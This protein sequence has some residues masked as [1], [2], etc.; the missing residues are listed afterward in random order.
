MKR[1]LA[2]LILLLL[3]LLA[4]GCVSGMQG[5]PYANATPGKKLY[6]LGNASQW[7]YAVNMSAN[8]TSSEWNMTVHNYAG[9]PRHMVIHTSGNGMDIIYDVWWNQTTYRVERMHAN[10]SIG[11]YYQDHDVSPLQIQTLP[12][13]G[14]NYYFVP[15]QPIR[16]VTARGPD[17]SMANLTV[18]AATDNQGFTVAYWIHPAV[19]V[20]AKI[21]MST[22]DFNITMMLTDYKQGPPLPPI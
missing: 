22:R 14:L 20:P 2:I 18:Y 12:D 8:E 16:T 4:S 13:T 3:A 15:F 19:P 17:G 11:D 9:S 6:D 1:E 10:G 21:L 7:A 5:S